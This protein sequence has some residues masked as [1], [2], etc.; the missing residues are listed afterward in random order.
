MESAENFTP[1]FENDFERSQIEALEK[2]TE[3]TCPGYPW[4]RMGT[5]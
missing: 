5:G 2:L 1:E 3:H 4:Q